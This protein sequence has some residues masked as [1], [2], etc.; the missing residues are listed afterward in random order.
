MNFDQF[1]LFNE[2]A[3]EY[4]LSHTTVVSKNIQNAS[5][6]TEDQKMFMPCMVGSIESQF[7]KM[8]AQILRAKKCLDV[9]TFTG[10]SALALAEAVQEGGKVVTLEND[11]SVAKTAQKIFDDSSV[12]DK[13]DLKVGQAAETMK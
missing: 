12:K 7:L 11:P 13:I 4:A 5:K 8:Q 3:E 9:G 10:M 2:G 6:V 1:T